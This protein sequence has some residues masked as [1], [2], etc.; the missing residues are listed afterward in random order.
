MVGCG[1]KAPA[2]ASAPAVTFLNRPL[3]E[4]PGP[5]GVS[6]GIDP[7]AAKENLLGRYTLVKEADR[8]AG[9]VLE[10]SYTGDYDGL[11]TEQINVDFCKGKLGFASVTFARNDERPVRWRW[12]KIVA[13]TTQAWGQPSEQKEPTP[14]SVPVSGAGQPVEQDDDLDDV[15]RQ[16]LGA[17]WTFAHHTQITVIAVP[18]EAGG[19]NDTQLTL[20]WM[21]LNSEVMAPC[22]GATPSA[23]R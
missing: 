20:V 1:R 19:A 3:R 4:L 15:V 12:Q 7:Q 13:D 14:S 17:G 23:T 2:K 9:A 8:D 22:R 11:P 6:W 21:A 5:L 10:Q 16:G 18:H